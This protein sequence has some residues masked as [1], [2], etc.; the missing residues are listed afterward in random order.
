PGSSWALPLDVARRGPAA[1][2]V[3]TLAI[4]QVR[5]VLP[6]LPAT[7]PRPVVTFDSSYDPIELARAIRAADPSERLACDGLVRLSR[8]CCF[9]RPPAPSSERG[10][11]RR[12]IYGTLLRLRDPATH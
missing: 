12:R 9:Y 1:A 10:R 7:Y 5:R 4:T 2:S 6:D 11:G 3:T 8:R